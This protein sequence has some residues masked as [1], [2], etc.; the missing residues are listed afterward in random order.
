M[1]DFSTN[2]QSA[3]AQDSFTYFVLIEVDLPSGTEYYTSYHSD[4]NWDG[5]VWLADGG[6]FSYDSPNFSSVVDKEAYKIVITDID[7][8][9]YSQFK[10]G[11][12]GRSIKVY[13]GICD[14]TTKKPLLDTDLNGISDIMNLYSGR[15]DSPNIDINWDTKN[16]V[17]EGTSPMADLDQINVTM[18]SKDGMDQLST[19][20]TTYDRMYEGSETQIA[21]GKI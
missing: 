1:R 4:I 8:Y 16:A 10:L 7:D 17:L 3:F 19:T 11:M 21:W 2:I 12:V 6:I 18:V 20:D 13:V 15:V 14:P 5:H 9:F